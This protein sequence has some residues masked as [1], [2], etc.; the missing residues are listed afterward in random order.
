MIQTKML[1]IMALAALTCISARAAAPMLPP[2]AIAPD[3]VAVIHMDAAHFTPDSLRTAA[4][5]LLGPNA[6]KADDMLGKF[7]EKYN[8]ASKAGVDGLTIVAGAKAKKAAGD[9]PAANADEPPA[10]GRSPMDSGNGILYMHLKPGADVK[11]IES[12]MKADMPA[13]KAEQTLFDRNKDYLVVHEKTQLLPG[14]P[15]AARARTFSDALGTVSEASVQIAFIPD[16]SAKAEMLKS[17]EKEGAPKGVK[18]TLPLLANS[19]WITLAVNFGNSPGLTVTAN[20]ADVGS[21]KQLSDSIN[22]A[23][24]DAKQ[25]AANPGPNAGA[26]GM[27]GPMIAPM[28]E[29]LKPSQ[30]GSNVSMSLKGDSLKMI[31]NLI[32]QFTGGMGGPGGGGPRPAPLRPPAQ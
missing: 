13:D 28:L 25:Q 27:I 3:T 1:G 17:A 29:G 26:M 20:T 22:S 10:H 9:A 21:G 23:L 6:Q 16:A 12:M 30:A 18:E 4:Q 32:M 19:K 14:T 8:K 24:A 15:D 2:D 5:T 11:A 7:T 31:A